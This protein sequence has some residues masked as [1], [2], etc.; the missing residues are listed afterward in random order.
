MY[1]NYV[2]LIKYVIGDKMQMQDEEKEMEIITQLKH[3]ITVLCIKRLRTSQSPVIV[4]GVIFSLMMVIVEII[5][6][7]FVEESYKSG[8]L[9]DL[10]VVAK[11]ALTNGQFEKMSRPKDVR[12]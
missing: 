12:N 9:E 3:D 2:S 5:H 6:N 10:F 4:H 7:S 1:V 11:D 8:V